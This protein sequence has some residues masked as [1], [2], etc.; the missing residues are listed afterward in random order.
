MA[1]SAIS[2]VVDGIAVYGDW[3]Q[4]KY[5][6]SLSST[7]YVDG[8]RLH[9]EQTQV[10]AA[11]VSWMFAF[12]DDDGVSWIHDLGL[13][14]AWERNN[15]NWGAS[16]RFESFSGTGDPHTHIRMI[17]TKVAPGAAAPVVAELTVYYIG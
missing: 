11:P 7:G 5:S 2:T 15:Y 3:I 8:M 10:A 14:S 1:T 12:S 17:V 16:S 6:N 9:I 4:C 13:G